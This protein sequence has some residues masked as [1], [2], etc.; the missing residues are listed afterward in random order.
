[1]TD[2]LDRSLLLAAS[3]DARGHGRVVDVPRAARRL[4]AALVL[5]GL[6]GVSVGTYALL[7]GTV[8][9]WLGLPAMFIGVTV[10]GFGLALGNR[11]INVTTYRPA[12]WSVPEWLVAA[13]GGVVGAGLLV[14]SQLGTAALNPS[15]Q[16]L[17]WPVLPIAACVIVLVGAI[18]VALA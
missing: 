10:G 18:P 6:C 16:L 1:M 8:P 11:R 9:H 15:A 14:M 2:A 7:D 13:C 4:S 12:P 3:M 5:T 17:D